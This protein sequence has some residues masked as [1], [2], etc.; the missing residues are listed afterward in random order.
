MINLGKVWKYLIL[1]G[2]IALILI[3]LVG[4]F[5]AL[6]DAKLPS[7]M[8]STILIVFSINLAISICL[9][10]AITNHH[11]CLIENHYLAI[12]S[13]LLALFFIGLCYWGVSCTSE[14]PYDLI[15]LHSSARHLLEDGT[16]GNDS[17][18]S[19]YPYQIFSTVFI[20]YLYKVGNLFCSDLRLIG[21]ICGSACI[22]L[23]LYYTASIVEE[24]ISKKSSIILMCL[25]ILNPI[26][27]FYS[28]Y[29]YSDC[30]STLFTSIAIYLLFKGSHT[31]SLVI[32]TFAGLVIALSILFRSTSFF[33]VVAYFF[34]W[35]VYSK[36]TVYKKCFNGILLSTE[37]LF[38][39]ALI[40]YLVYFIYLNEVD[41]SKA[42]P[43]TH[44]IM[45]G[46]DV[47]HKGRYWAGHEL[48]TQNL[49]N[50]GERVE[51]AHL[52][53][54]LEQFRSHSL[55]EWLGLFYQK[56]SQLWSSGYS[57]S[58]VMLTNNNNYS[59]LYEISRGN[60]SFVLSYLIQS[61]RIILLGSLILFLGLYKKI[62]EFY[63]SEKAH[64]FLEVLLV[65]VI[66]YACFY[67][68]FE[69]S[70]RYLRSI[71]FVLYV[72]F[73]VVGGCCNLNVRKYQESICR[74]QIYS[75]VAIVMLMFTCCLWADNYYEL[76]Q[77]KV[78]YL[79]PSVKQNN[80][81][82]ILTVSTEI[83][84]TF[85]APNSF[86][87][88]RLYVDPASS[89]EGYTFEVKN[90]SS[91]GIQKVSSKEVKVSSNGELTI[92]LK[93]FVQGSYVLTIR[94]S[95]RAQKL[96][97]FKAYSSDVY[98][99]YEHGQIS[100]TNANELV[101]YNNF[102]HNFF[103]YLRSNTKIDACKFSDLKFNVY[104]QEKRPILSKKAYVAIICFIL[105]LQILIY[106]G[107]YRYAL[108]SW[109]K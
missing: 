90:L 28:S 2:R 54:L 43:I 100:L 58:N 67:L 53:Y 37:I 74:P 50:N 18:Y 64:C 26:F 39:Y 44:W 65:F 68:F 70:E 7:K 62:C 11:I 92:Y 52:Q 8:Q 71:L 10:I 87:R 27:Y 109:K 51:F 84:Q 101:S 47:D 63:K 29:Y 31:Y 21:A 9:L 42:Y 108:V 40:K 22:A 97:R 23:S 57:G 32:H 79:L 102:E 89:V 25:V 86:N 75:I 66:L 24:V 46:L 98:D 99:Y 59:V 73:A 82:A 35:M 69:S 12:K 14:R 93:R 45:M 13:F 105:M 76:T 95:D 36:R 20:Y 38:F 94:K 30:W 55:I 96:S 77:K 88:I 15:H 106:F 85:T 33:L 91:N 3:L 107:F 56:I 103:E 16:L 5:G 78:N 80:A 60:K 6:F 4:L 48:F 61:E 34:V 83:E 1:F 19:K 72:F 17:Y 49:L 81:N 41:F 104:Y